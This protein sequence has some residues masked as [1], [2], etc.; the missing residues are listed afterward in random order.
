MSNRDDGYEEL[1]EFYDYDIQKIKESG[2]RKEKLTSKL[3]RVR[4]GYIAKM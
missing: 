3:H 2:Q 1:S 4:D